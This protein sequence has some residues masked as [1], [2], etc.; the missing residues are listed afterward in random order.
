MSTNCFFVKKI[1]ISKFNIDT[2]I[3]FLKFEFCSIQVYLGE[4]IQ[5]REASE[6]FV[7]KEQNLKMTER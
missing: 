5:P 1:F 3:T 6:E 7:R 4:G 2:K